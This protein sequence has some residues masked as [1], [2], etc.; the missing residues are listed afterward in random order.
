MLTDSLGRAYNKRMVKRKWM[1]AY[2]ASGQKYWLCPGGCGTPHTVTG[3][4]TCI[5]CDFSYEALRV[6]GQRVLI[7]EVKHETKS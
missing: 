5:T 6:E 7:E 4:I 2:N 1:N 3:Y